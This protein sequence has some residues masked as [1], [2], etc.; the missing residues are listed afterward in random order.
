M[1]L[2]QLT[3][4]SFRAVNSSPIRSITELESRFGISYLAPCDARDS[5]LPA[6]SFSFISNTSTLEHIPESDLLKVLVECVR[7]L[8]PKGIMS[9][10]IDMKDH[11][12]Y[13]DSSIS[14]YNFLK[15]SDTAWKLIDSPLH[16]Q[17][18]L[19]Y[20]DYKKLFEISD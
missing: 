3:N 7:L 2:E 16:F 15:F 8:K 19:R 5:K 6:E 9:S 10:I 20:P 18:R 11:Y 14:C 13:H 1:K 4:A 17:N 12:S